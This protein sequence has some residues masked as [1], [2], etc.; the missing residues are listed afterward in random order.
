MATLERD[1]RVI[2]LE[3]GMS[4]RT[5]DT[6]VRHLMQIIEHERE[7]SWQV[8]YDAGHAK[9]SA[10]GH[11]TGLDEAYRNAEV[12]VD[13]YLSLTFAEKQRVKNVIHTGAPY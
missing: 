9:G 8:G 12:N 10:D 3:Y 7:N 13:N 1:I 2:V 6:T 5:L 4:K 11:Q